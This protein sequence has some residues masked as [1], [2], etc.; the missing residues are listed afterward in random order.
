MSAGSP[1]VARDL[2]RILQ[3]LSGMVF[4]SVVASLVWGEFYAVPALVVAGLLPLAVGRGSTSRY[5]GTGDPFDLAR[6]I[7]T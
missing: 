5:A 1:V 2:G 4:V 3:A 6:W 7:R